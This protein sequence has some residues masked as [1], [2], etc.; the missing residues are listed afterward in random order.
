[1]DDRRKWERHKT[2]DG[3]YV[4]LPPYEELVEFAKNHPPPQSWFEEDFSGLAGPQQE[5]MTEQTDTSVASKLT[6]ARR[7]ASGAIMAREDGNRKAA[8]E[9][10]RK[11]RRLRDEAEA[12]DVG[13]IDAAW[14]LK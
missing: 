1:M 8:E 6:Q 13:H 3:G 14:E 5:A 7:A 9:L 4:D 11:A 12:M 2:A 10:E